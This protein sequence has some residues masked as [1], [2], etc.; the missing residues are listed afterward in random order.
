MAQV[1]HS[2]QTD[3]QAAFAPMP[4]VEEA[5]AGEEDSSTAATWQQL[6]LLGSGVHCKLRPVGVVHE[7]HEKI[8]PIQKP[9]YG[10]KPLPHRLAATY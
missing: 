4:A 2:K 1:T 10:G 3:P 9:L 5:V 7:T 8:V 6:S